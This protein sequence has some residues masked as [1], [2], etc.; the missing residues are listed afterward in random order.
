MVNSAL[1]RL[2]TDSAVLAGLC[3]VWAAA[4][5]HAPQGVT[6]IPHQFN[7]SDAVSVL[8]ARVVLPHTL[9]GSRVAC[10]YPSYLLR[11]DARSTWICTAQ[12]LA[13]ATSDKSHT[14]AECPVSCPGCWLARSLCIATD[15]I[16]APAMML[17]PAA[18]DTDAVLT[19]PDAE[20]GAGAPARSG[21]DPASFPA[22][23]KVK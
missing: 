6:I 7:N 4:A 18:T 9:T 3:N 20:A 19:T 22:N 5:Q 17:A 8:P 21:G 2:N 15:I 12:G 14:V 11:V 10:M 13:K 16:S 1:G 23:D